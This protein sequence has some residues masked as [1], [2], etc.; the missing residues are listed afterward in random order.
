MAFLTNGHDNGIRKWVGWWGGGIFGKI[1]YEGGSLARST[2]REDLWQDPLRG[3]IFGK[4]HYEGRDLWQDP[5]R[6]G[7]FGKIHY[8]KGLGGSDA[9][10]C[11]SH[12]STQY[13]SAASV[14]SPLLTLGQSPRMATFE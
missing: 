2:T 11:A 5:L 12:D 3:G 7:I 6:G 14:P 10:R 1:H 4:I 9:F 8:G 13:R